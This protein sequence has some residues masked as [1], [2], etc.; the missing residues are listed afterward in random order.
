M[1]KALEEKRGALDGSW[2]RTKKTKDETGR[3]NRAL[4]VV[5]ES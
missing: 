5:S 2:H 4:P 3:L 1:I